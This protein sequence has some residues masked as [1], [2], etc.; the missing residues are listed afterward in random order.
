MC[1][2]VG[3]FWPRAFQTMTGHTR[4]WA[5]ATTKLDGGCAATHLCKD[6]ERWLL[7]GSLGA[8]KHLEWLLSEQDGRGEEGQAA[9]LTEDRG[10]GARTAFCHTL[11]F[12]AE[13]S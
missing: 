3:W 1:T 8:W 7:A 10:S 6:K 4:V 5:A 12:G 11:P 9:S 13:C 2:V